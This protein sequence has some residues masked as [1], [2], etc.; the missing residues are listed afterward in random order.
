MDRL[1]LTLDIHNLGSKRV[2][3]RSS[4]LVS[5]L[6]ARIQ[7]KFSLDGQYELRLKS[8][9]APLSKDQALTEAGVQEGDTLACVR[10]V[11][12]SET[13]NAIRRGTRAPFSQKFNRVYVQEAR[14]LTEFDLQWQPAILG[15]KDQRDPSRNRLLAVDL[16]DMEELPTISRH[17]ACIT[18]KNGTFYIEGLQPEN[19]VFVD[20][21]KL[22]AGKN[23]LRTGAKIQIGS[24]I[25]TFQLIS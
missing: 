6:I 17:H 15:R 21:Q 4:L 7:D 16:A 8:A 5:S 18:E 1:N 10:V 22:R 19:P 3:V 14:T 25:L 24:V 20:D 13:M 9:R 11:D 12:V 23:P 2:N